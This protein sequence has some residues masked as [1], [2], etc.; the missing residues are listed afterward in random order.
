M[1]FILIIGLHLGLQRLDFGIGEMDF[2][3][4][5]TNYVPLLVILVARAWLI[6][7]AQVFDSGARTHSI[8]AANRS[9]LHTLDI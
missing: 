8:L 3:I 9:F 4:R 2:W 6:F 5:K 7:R 1:K